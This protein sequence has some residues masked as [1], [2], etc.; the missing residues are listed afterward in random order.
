LLVV[1]LAVACTGERPTLAGTVDAQSTTTLPVDPNLTI[2]AEATLPAI[3]VY[4]SKGA[5]VADLSL[6]ASNEISGRLIFLVLSEEDDW[7][8]VLLPVQDDDGKGWVRA[9]DVGL[10]RHDYRIE[11]ELADHRLRVF[12]GS[13]NV[14]DEPIAIGT[15]DAPEPGGDRYIKELLRPPDPDGPYGQYAYGFSGHSNALNDFEVG[16]GVIGIHGT[17]DPDSIGNDVDHGCIRLSND[18]MTRLV[19]EVGLPLGTPVEI[20]P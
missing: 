20:R 15:T 6:T 13:T 12:Q 19:D 11:I 9:A 8:E 18:A 7:L 1:L 10:S 4:G 5:E 2:V 3:D 17:N 14:M 16:D